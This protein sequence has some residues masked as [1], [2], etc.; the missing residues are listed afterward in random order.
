MTGDQIPRPTIEGGLWAD[1]LTPGQS[2]T[3][4]SHSLTLADVVGFATEFDPQPFHLDE[5][6]AAG[7]FFD[8]V[9]ASGWHTS[10]ITMRLLVE[11]VPLATGLIGARCESSWPT[12]S[13]P[14]DVL[15]VE[16]VV[17]EVRWSKSRPGRASLVLACR[18]V[19]EAGA[20]RQEM[21]TRLIAWARPPQGVGV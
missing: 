14:G 21:Q 8:R 6:R 19:N 9:V 15:H 10:A 16:V 20:V 5:Q 13:L 17:D 11:T 18:T 4:R 3:S 1:D 12:A 2:F 7:T